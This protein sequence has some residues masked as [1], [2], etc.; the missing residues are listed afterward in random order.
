MTT[1]TEKDDQD[2]ETVVH[3]LAR[4]G[5]C[6]LRALGARPELSDWPFIRVERAVV[7]A[8]SDGVLSVDREDRLLAL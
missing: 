7:Q 1:H 8:W 4:F 5:P 3:L 2:R 6:T